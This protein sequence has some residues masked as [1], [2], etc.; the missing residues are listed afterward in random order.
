MYFKILILY[1]FIINTYLNI[2]RPLFLKKIQTKI[3]IIMTVVKTKI[4]II[5]PQINR[6]EKLDLTDKEL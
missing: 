5:N 2:T 4:L 6:V 3:I 1:Y